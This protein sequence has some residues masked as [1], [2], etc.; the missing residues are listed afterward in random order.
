[1][2]IAADVLELAGRMLLVPPYYSDAERDFAVAASAF[3]AV[4]GVVVGRSMLRGAGNRILGVL[5]LLL[6]AIFFAYWLVLYDMG[7]VFYWQTAFRS[8]FFSGLGV[9]SSCGGDTHHEADDGEGGGEDQG[10]N[11]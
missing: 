10:G 3:F 1:M 2:T 7:G 4:V 11:D 8:A 9:L 5:L 6:I